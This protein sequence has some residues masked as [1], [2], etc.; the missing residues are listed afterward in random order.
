MRISDWSS[1]VCSSDLKESSH[2]APLGNDEIAGARAALGWPHA[3]F[4]IPQSIYAGWRD[5]NSGAAREAAWQALFADYAAQHPELAREFTRRISGALPAE[6]AA[7][8][9]DFIASL[10]PE[11]PAVGSGQASQMELAGA[12]EA[13]GR[14]RVSKY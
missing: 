10:Q 8:P 11:G 4:E 7:N 12:G 3:P 6:F 1:D 2:G 9:D 5:G 13:S 14:D